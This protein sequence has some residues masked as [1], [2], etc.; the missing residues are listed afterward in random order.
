MKIFS[1]QSHYRYVGIQTQ[2]LAFLPN[3]PH[4]FE[5]Q[6]LVAMWAETAQIF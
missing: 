3:L 5:L 4:N 6:F 1:N 2:Y